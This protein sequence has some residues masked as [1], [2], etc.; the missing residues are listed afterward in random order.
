MMASYVAISDQANTSLHPFAPL[1]PSHLAW[2]HRERALPRAQR[3]A[4]RITVCCG[5]KRSHTHTHTLAVL[6]AVVRVGH[7]VDST[8]KELV[9]LLLCGRTCPVQFVLLEIKSGS[10]STAGAVRPCCA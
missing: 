6:Q 3:S 8:G 9:D 4:R 1:K 7:C 10:L 5:R 2:P